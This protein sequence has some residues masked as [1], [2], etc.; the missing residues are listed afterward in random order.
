MKEKLKKLL[1]RAISDH[2]NHGGAGEVES[3]DSVRVMLQTWNLEVV[4]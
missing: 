3:S 1:W 2:L 4:K